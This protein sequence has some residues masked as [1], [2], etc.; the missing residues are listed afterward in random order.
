VETEWLHSD[1]DRTIGVT[2]G[3]LPTPFAG[4]VSSTRQKLEFRERN[5]SAYAAQLLGDGFSIGARYRLSEA[6]LETRLPELPNSTTDLNLAE[7]SERSLLHQVALSLNYQHTSGFFGQWESVWYYQHNSGYTPARPGDDFFQ[8][9]LWLGYR[10][11][12]RHAEIRAGLLNLADTDYR[13]N[14]LNSY[15]ALPRSR[16]AVVSLRLNF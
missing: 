1:G 2:T 4:A 9:N 14:P 7:Q 15:N 5:L 10:F 6:Q 8:H 13:L 16:T 11:P 12:R 3:V